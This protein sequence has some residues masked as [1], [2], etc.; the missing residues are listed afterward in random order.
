MD[1]VVRSFLKASLLWLSLGVTVGVAMGVHPV[2]TVYRPVHEHMN[3]LGFVSMMIFGVAYHVIPRFSGNALWRRELAVWHSWAANVGLALMCVGFVLRVQSAVEP[4]VGGALLGV[5]GSLSAVGAYLFAYNIWRT[6]GG[7]A[8]VLD[9]R[10]A[11]QR[12]QQRAPV[13]GA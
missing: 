7:A 13:R 11:Q 2:W 12:A 8:A 5:G 6:I 1:S 4:A 10:R 3:L 9:V